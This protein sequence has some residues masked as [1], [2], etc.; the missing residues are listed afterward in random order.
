MNALARLSGVSASTVSRWEAGTTKPCMPELESVLCVL[1]PK[2]FVR[3]RLIQSIGAPRTIQT[4][5]QELSTTGNSPIIPAP[6]AGGFLKAMRN[7]KRMS[8]EEVA[9]RVGIAQSTLARW[10]KGD[11]WPSPI[12]LHTLCYILGAT[13]GEISALTNNPASLSPSADNHALTYEDAWIWSDKLKADLL[14]QTNRDLIELHYWQL[15]S[16]LWGEHSKWGAS[17]IELYS[18]VLAR[19]AYF[20]LDAKPGKIGLA[21]TARANRAK[22]FAEQAIS[23]PVAQNS[24]SALVSMIVLSQ[25]YA[26]SDLRKAIDIVTPWTTRK[27]SHKWKTGGNEISPE[28]AGWSLSRLSKLMERYG[29]QSV[30]DA[31]SLQAI[32]TVRSHGNEIETRV[33]TNDRVEMLLR[34]SRFEEVLDILPTDDPGGKVLRYWESIL[35]AEALNGTG[36]ADQAIERI[37]SLQPG[38]DTKDEAYFLERAELIRQQTCSS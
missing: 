23:A 2:D 31:L 19:F 20:H 22:Y 16:A 15:I 5:R 11:H 13:E 8:Q 25:C 34:M 36:Q 3:R 21:A 14:D 33:R 17:G 4:L 10:E 28:A 12:E 38:L 37:S 24:G 32:R 6:T 29:K 1:K 9:S 18:E 27:V 7:R 26:Q 35:W 30:A